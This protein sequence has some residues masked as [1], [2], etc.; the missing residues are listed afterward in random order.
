MSGIEDDFDIDCIHVNMR[1][2][3]MVNVYKAFDKVKKENKEL[4]DTV[5]TFK[6]MML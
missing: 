4:K 1:Y 5:K 3:Q 6:N 2:N